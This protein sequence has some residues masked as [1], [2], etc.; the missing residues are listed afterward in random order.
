MTSTRKAYLS[1][2]I[3]R[4]YIP[5]AQPDYSVCPWDRPVLGRP[6][7]DDMADA[8]VL[9]ELV[10]SRS[11]AHCPEKAATA[12]HWGRPHV[13]GR[14]QVVGVDTDED[15]RSEPRLEP[16]TPSSLTTPSSSSSG[17]VRLRQILYL[18]VDDSVHIDTDPVVATGSAVGLD[19]VVHSMELGYARQ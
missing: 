1:P 17:D 9:A 10:A 11:W 13:E 15:E 19:P 8:P 3:N 12:K 16:L 5:K 7:L 14:S 6:D 4:T 18:W 2:S